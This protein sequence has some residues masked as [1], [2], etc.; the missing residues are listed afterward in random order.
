M[1][2]ANQ[3]I[4]IQDAAGMF[5]K[6]IGQNERPYDVAIKRYQNTLVDEY[7]ELLRGLK[8]PLLVGRAMFVLRVFLEGKETLKFMEQLENLTVCSDQQLK[9]WVD[10]MKQPME[11][12][13]EGGPSLVKIAWS[14]ITD[15]IILESRKVKYEAI[16]KHSL[17]PSV[18]IELA[19]KQPSLFDS[20]AT[21]YPCGITREIYTDMFDKY[22]AS[23]IKMGGEN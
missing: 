6:T 1:D 18:W 9:F 8:G 14:I 4:S 22:R 10:Y 7:E 3:T 12:I 15:Q 5:R 19:T 21:S 23:G 13:A 16:F 11:K 17:N 20:L 2:P